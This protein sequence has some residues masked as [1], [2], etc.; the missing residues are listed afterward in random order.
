[1]P[2]RDWLDDL[3][4]LRIDGRWKRRSIGGDFD[5]DHERQRGAN[6]GQPR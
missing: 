5:D 1:M 4:L 2:W 6:S 3:H